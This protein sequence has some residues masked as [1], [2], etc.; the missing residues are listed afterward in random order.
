MMKLRL[1]SQPLC[2]AL[3]ILLEWSPD[4]LGCEQLPVWTVLRVKFQ[5]PFAFLERKL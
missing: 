1:Y 3:R 2:A 5:Q 4:I